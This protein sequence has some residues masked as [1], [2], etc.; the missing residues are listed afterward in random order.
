MVM[1]EGLD[2]GPILA[3]RAVEIRSD[4]TGGSLTDLLADLGADLLGETLPRH[5]AGE[6]EPQ[7]QDDRLATLAP[8]LRTSDGALDPQSPA[9]DLERRIRA[10]SPRPGSRLRW[11]QDMLRVL[12]SHVVVGPTAHPGTVVAL[13]GLP[14]M[15]TGEGCLA[16]DE[17][18]LPGGRPTSGAA[19]LAGHRS[20][21]GSVLTKPV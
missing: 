1:D 2:T 19:F 11:G 3:Q 20:L 13:D 6:L 17:V 8:R 12:A 9:T 10:F 21:V 15:A 16:L 4:H 5:A 14:A 7:P 18:Q